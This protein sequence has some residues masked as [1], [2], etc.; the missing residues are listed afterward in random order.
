MPLDSTPRAAIESTGPRHATTGKHPVGP[1]D[2]RSV[3]SRW[4]RTPCHPRNLRPGPDHARK[5]GASEAYANATTTTT[6]RAPSGVIPSPVQDMIRTRINDAHG[7]HRNHVTELQDQVKTKI[8]KLD[9][10]EDGYP[11]NASTH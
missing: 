11:S 8:A 3:P 2:R 6:S 9:R 5:T 10:Q 7:E 4:A 1:P